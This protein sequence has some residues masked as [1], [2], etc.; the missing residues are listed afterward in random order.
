MISLTGR[1]SFANELIK[2]EK[3]IEIISIR[4]LE[5]KVFWQKLKKTNILIH[6]AA[7]INCENIDDC[8]LKNFDFTRKIL[9]FLTTNNPTVNFTYI[10]SMSIL[11]PK[12][13]KIILDIDKMT[14]YAVSKYKAEQYCINSNINNLKIVRFSTIFYKNP[15]KDGLSKLIYDAVTKHEITLYNDGEATRDFI[16]LKIAVSYVKNIIKLQNINKKIFNVVSGTKTSFKDIALLLKKNIPD[17]KIININEKNFSE[18]LS[19]FS[20]DSIK[21]LEEIRFNLEEI[22]EEYINE[23][24]SSL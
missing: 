18:V 10:S 21:N 12:S 13:D 15:K 5:E 22:V 8:L 2:Q 20:K 11:D 7:S 19:D 24:K 4:E 3:A 16:P 9:D 17:L 6:N 1:G 23:I 14:P